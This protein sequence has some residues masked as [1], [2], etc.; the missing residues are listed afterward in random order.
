MRLTEAVLAVHGAN[1]AASSSLAKNTLITLSLPALCFMFSSQSK[2]GEYGQG[3]ILENLQTTTSPFSSA[4][5]YSHGHSAHTFSG[6][7]G[8][9]RG[10]I[11]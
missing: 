2:K 7:I 11:I 3:Y 8:R 6:D 4:A 1:G 10:G 9:P 5:D